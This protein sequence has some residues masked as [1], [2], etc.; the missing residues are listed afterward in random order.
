[1]FADV[2]CMHLLMSAQTIWL[3][4]F[5]DLNNGSTLKTYW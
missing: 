1:M 5:T 3:H 2:V 4:T